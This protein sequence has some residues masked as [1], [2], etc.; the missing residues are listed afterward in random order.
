MRKSNLFA[1]AAVMALFASPLLGS[2]A[3]DSAQACW[4]PAF[5]AGDAD[6]VSQ[7][8]APDAV[9]WLGGMQMMQ[10]RDAIREGYAGFFSAYAVK[11]VKLVT[12]GQSAHGDEATA[13]GSYSMVLVSKEDGKETLSTGRY[14]DVSRKVDGKWMYVVDH[15][16][17]NPPA[18]VEAAPAAAN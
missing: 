14:T 18:A 12:I 15:A 7:C 3:P 17:E 10:G 11:D 1:M 13:W 8:Y 9:F 16:S 6:A 4:Q 5:E 2:D